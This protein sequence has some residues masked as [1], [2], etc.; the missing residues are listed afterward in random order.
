M[1]AEFIAPPGDHGLPAMAI[2][3]YWVF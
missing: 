2:E 1:Q 3:S